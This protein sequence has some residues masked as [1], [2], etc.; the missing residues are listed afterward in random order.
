MARYDKFISYFWL[1]LGLVVIY[2]GYKIGLGRLNNPGGGLFIFILGVCLFLLALTIFVSSCSKKMKGTLSM[3]TLLADWKW[4]KPF[5]IFLA[6]IIYTLVIA[7]LGYCLSTIFLLIFLFNV[8]ER[9]EWK[10]V[11]LEVFLTVFLSFLSFGIF[12]EVRFPRGPFEILI[13]R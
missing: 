2:G 5:Y 12:L 3:S 7:K 4:K 1:F 9:Q 10:T 6:L 13:G 11:M 8:I